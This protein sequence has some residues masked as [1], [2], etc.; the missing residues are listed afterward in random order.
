MGILSFFTGRDEKEAD[1]YANYDKVSNVTS[2]I[3]EISSS[4]ETSISVI[5]S[6]ANEINSCKGVGDFIEPCNTAGIVELLTSC[7]SQ[8]ESIGTEITNKANDIKTY[9]E[10]SWLEKVGSTFAM[11]GAKLGEGVLKVFE[12]MGDGI[13]SAVGWLAPKDSGLEQACENFV[14]KELAHDAFSGYYNSEFAKKSLYTENSGLAGVTKFAGQ[15]GTFIVLGNGISKVASKLTKSESSMLR[16]VGTFAQSEKRLD[17]AQA[18]LEG[19]GTGTDEALNQG[20]SMDEAAVGGVKRAA[21]QGAFA[22][23]VGTAIEKLKGASA[24]KKAATEVVGGA[25]NASL[26]LASG[27]GVID[28]VGEGATRKLSGLVSS[29]ADEAAGLLAR[30]TDDTTSLVVRHADDVAT[31]V[32]DVGEKVLQELDEGVGGIEKAS[33]QFR[34]SAAG[35]LDD[36]LDDAIISTTHN[37]TSTVSEVVGDGASGAL[38]HTES[39]KVFHSNMTAEDASNNLKQAFANL[40]DGG[41][42]KVNFNEGKFKGMLKSKS[43]AEVSA[44]MIDD[45]Y[46]KQLGEDAYK[47]FKYTDGA[48]LRAKQLEFLNSAASGKVD[49]AIRALENQQQRLLSFFDKF[50]EGDTNSAAFDYLFRMKGNY[51]TN[52]LNGYIDDILSGKI[53][54]TLLKNFAS[55]LDNEAGRIFS[56]EK[57]GGYFNTIGV[58]DKFTYDEITDIYNKYFNGVDFNAKLGIEG[59]SPAKMNASK[60]TTEEISM[61]KRYYNNSITDD[62]LAKKLGGSATF[63]S[64]SLFQEY[65][66]YTGKSVTDVLRMD[67]SASTIDKEIKQVLLDGRAKK[68]NEIFSN[69]GIDFNRIVS[70]SSSTPESIR[71]YILDVGFRY[72]ER[73][74]T[75]S[76]NVLKSVFEAVVDNPEARKEFD[77]QMLSKIYKY[78]GKEGVPSSANDAILRVLKSDNQVG[79]LRDINSAVERARASE[80]TGILSKNSTFNSILSNDVSGDIVSRISRGSDVYFSE[81]AINQKMVSEILQNPSLSAFRNSDEFLSC[82]NDQLSR[83]FGNSSKYAI[84]RSELDNLISNGTSSYAGIVNNRIDNVLSDSLNNYASALNSGDKAQISSALSN[85]R[86]QQQSVCSDLANGIQKVAGNSTL[87][88]NITD[89][90]KNFVEHILMFDEAAG[91]DGGGHYLSSLI[92]PYTG[93]NVDDVLGA[94]KIITTGDKPTVYYAG[95]KKTIGKSMWGSDMTIQDIYDIMTNGTNYGELIEKEIRGNGNYVLTRVIDGVQYTTIVD[96]SNNIITC[97]PIKQ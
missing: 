33:V 26:A 3:S 88:G 60:F 86:A 82:V 62:L 35:H 63:Q 73:A 7:R 93:T 12:D 96:K 92:K 57:L 54:N 36:G 4:M 75:Q 19:M 18:V 87:S 58:N 10:A 34:S 79:V 38:S 71:E 84:T 28:D 8:I 42:Y 51:K 70:N 17:V 30:H 50:P 80:I 97:F 81:N 21:I 76:Q 64:E 44:A 89:Y 48:S 5:E 46:K 29:Q 49:D 65:L 20:L 52:V 78:A 77:N 2:N 6:A 32:D 85:L 14:K 47:L 23:G 67:A 68:I 13:V 16:A 66:D 39:V 24:A 37:T 45:F 91:K 22:W 9:E 95:G 74:D 55:D 59:V 11:T 53:D 72:S 15:L 41:K 1:V 83:S 69:N 27:S 31:H 90:D 43:P 25:D 94:S 40:N 56:A 61:L